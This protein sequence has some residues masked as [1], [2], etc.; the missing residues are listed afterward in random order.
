MKLKL[1]RFQIGPLS[2]ML[3]RIVV[4]LTITLT[5]EAQQ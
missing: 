5:A 3:T 1:S 2:S 4:I